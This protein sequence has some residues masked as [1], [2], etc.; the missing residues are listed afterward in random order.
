MG[1]P[2]IRMPALADGSRDHGRTGALAGARAGVLEP[3]VP[4][5]SPPCRPR[6]EP[7]AQACLVLLPP[8]VLST[9]RASCAPGAV[10]QLC[11][12]GP[13]EEGPCGCKSHVCRARWP[14]LCLGG[15]GQRGLGQ[16]PLLRCRR[17]LSLP[18]PQGAC[19]TST[20]M[21]ARTAPAT[22]VAP[23]RTASTASPAAAPRATTT[24][25]A[26]RRSTSATATPV[27]TGPAGTAS[28]G[29]HRP[30]EAAAG[31][32]G[33]GWGGAATKL[34]MGCG[35]PGPSGWV[36]PRR[37]IQPGT[38]SALARA[39]RYRGPQRGLRKHVCARQRLAILRPCVQ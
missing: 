21:S 7:G 34:Q 13:W 29:A 30:R 27:S 17:C 5:Q 37:R 11:P 20:L 8:S 4:G 31:G 10:G 2:A 6:A 14:G 12:R 39:R 3:L 1:G 32:E 25:P 22:T 33:A 36:L 18:R 35:G 16:R 26:C 38:C 28:T 15:R 19:A 9:S 23:A 24:P